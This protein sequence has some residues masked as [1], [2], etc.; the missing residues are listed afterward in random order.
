MSGID[1]DPAVGDDAFDAMGQFTN[2]VA[3]DVRDPYPGLAQKRREAPVE[4]IT[5]VDFAGGEAPVAN[6]YTYDA[7]AQVLRDNV[8]FS[9]GA[10]RELMEL[11]MGPFGGVPAAVVR[12]LPC[13]FWYHPTADIDA[14]PRVER[15]DESRAVNSAD[16]G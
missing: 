8:T 14:C 1:L 16:S 9:S 15:R 7:V 10:I 4:L 12:D 6:I 3:G 13:A 2:T 5:Q 11:V